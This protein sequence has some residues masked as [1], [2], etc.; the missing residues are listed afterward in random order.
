MSTTLKVDIDVGQVLALTQGLASHPAQ[1]R[2][3]GQKSDRQGGE[4]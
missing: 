1:D 3:V 2:P 4:R